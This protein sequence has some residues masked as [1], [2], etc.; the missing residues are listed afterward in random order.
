MIANPITIPSSA[1][2]RSEIF[3]RQSEIKSLRELLK[4]AATAERS[5][6]V[7]TM[8]LHTRPPMRLVPAEDDG[9][10]RPAA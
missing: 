1:E 4:I 8:P 5:G 6:V 10:R 3:R 7:P 2:L 9:D